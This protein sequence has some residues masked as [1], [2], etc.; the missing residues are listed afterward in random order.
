MTSRLLLDHGTKLVELKPANI[1]QAAEADLKRVE[2]NTERSIGTYET[3]AFHRNHVR[4]A[5]SVI[6]L[7]RFAL[8]DRERGL[9]SS[10]YNTRLI[11]RDAELLQRALVEAGGMPMEEVT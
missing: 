5:E 8:Q 7:I 3:Y 4:K 6:E 11:Y 10:K 9:I 1:V 2:I